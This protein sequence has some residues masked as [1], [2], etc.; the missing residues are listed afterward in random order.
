MRIQIETFLIELNEEIYTI[1]EEL[2]NNS[3]GLKQDMHKKAKDYE[4][5]TNLLLRKIQKTFN[6]SD[7]VST[8]GS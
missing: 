4:R 7:S 2:A 1:S 3:Q 5:R 8:N 6:V